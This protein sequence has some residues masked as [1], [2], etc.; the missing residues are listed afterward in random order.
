MASTRT[1]KNTGPGS[2][3]RTARRRAKTRMKASAI[4]KIFTFSRKAREISG[5]E[6]R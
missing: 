5:N 4:R 2:P 6:S 3:R 1:G